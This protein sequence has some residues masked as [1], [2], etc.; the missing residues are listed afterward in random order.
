MLTSNEYAGKMF[1]ALAGNGPSIQPP[2][3]QIPGS[4]RKNGGGWIKRSG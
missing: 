3:K 2:D 4:N 1:Y